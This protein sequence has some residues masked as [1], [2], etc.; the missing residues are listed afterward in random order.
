MAFEEVAVYVNET[1]LQPE[2]G[3]PRTV[4]PGS[5]FT[6]TFLFPDV[7]FPH[8]FDGVAITFPELPGVDVKDVPEP[9]L[10]DQSAGAIQ[11]YD[12][13]F[14]ALVV[15]VNGDPAQPEPGPVTVAAP[16][17]IFV[18]VTFSMP[19]GPFPQLLDGTA[20]TF[21]ELPGVDVKLVPD[22]VFGDQ[23]AG[24]VQL[25]EVA[26]VEVALNV[27]EAPRQPE[28]GPVTT[29]VPGS[30]QFTV[31]CVAEILLVSFDSDTTPVH[32]FVIHPSAQKNI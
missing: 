31:N 3:P 26:P 17:K 10:G 2:P 21:P 12:E 8:P 22:P 29:A 32:P 15:N 24:A 19:K 13:A 11:L 18:I 30:V 25:N 5:G 27:N 20:V 28:P 9:V 4:E 6:V 7:P 1:P 14:V 16:G 23:S